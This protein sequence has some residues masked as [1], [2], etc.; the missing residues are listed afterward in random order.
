MKQIVLAIVGLIP[1]GPAA[2]GQPSDMLSGVP[3]VNDLTNYPATLVARPEP[4]ETVTDPQS[5]VTIR[6]ITDARGFARRAVVPMYPERSHGTQTSRCCCFRL[7]AGKTPPEILRL[8]HDFTALCGRSD[9][10]LLME[11]HTRPS[12]DDRYWG[13][14]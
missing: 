14:G 1:A 3:I 7:P 10:K 5:G 9:Y 6:R 11:P 4:D 8:R 2:F 13:F 12:W